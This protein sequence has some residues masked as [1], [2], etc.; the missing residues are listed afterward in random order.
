MAEH[1]RTD[2]FALLQSINTGED[3]WESLYSKEIKPINPKE[4]QP[5][6]FF[7]RTDAEPEAPI[8]FFLLFQMFIV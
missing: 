8:L 7:E 3:S 2:A 5:W 1:Q 4:N 6:I